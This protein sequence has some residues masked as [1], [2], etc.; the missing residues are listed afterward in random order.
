MPSATYPGH[1]ENVT[2]VIVTLR[3]VLSG[4]GGHAFIGG[5]ESLSKHS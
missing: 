3:R 1:R 5:W 4:D 2:E